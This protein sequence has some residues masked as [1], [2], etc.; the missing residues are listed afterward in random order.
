MTKQIRHFVGLALLLAAISASAQITHTIEVKVP[1]SFIAAGKNWPAADYRVK[2]DKHTGFV[3][4]TTAGIAPATV[5]TN[6]DDRPGEAGQTY[7]RFRRYG[8]RWVLQE[9]TQDGTAQLLNMGKLE[10]QVAKLNSPGQV[11]TITAAFAAR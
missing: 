2:I 9:V 11:T 8:E 3:T 4:L 5:L 6:K 7:L 1:F 10:R